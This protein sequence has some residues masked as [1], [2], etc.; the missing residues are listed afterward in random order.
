MNRHRQYGPLDDQDEPIGDAAFQ[1]LDMQ[2]DPAALAPG[3]VTLSENFRFNQLLPDGRRGAL[4][5][6]GLRRRLAPGTDPGTIL[7]VGIYRPEGSHDQFALVTT[8]KLVIF[9]PADQTLTDY[10]YLGGQTV[11]AAD[12]PDFIQG[13]LDTGTTPTAWILRGLSKA[14]LQFD[15]AVVAVDAAFRR[16]LFGMF[17]ENNRM[18]VASGDEVTPATTSQEVSVS[19]YLDFTE[20]SLLNQ[21]KILTGGDDHLMAFL[22]YQKN[23]ALIA[24]RKRF[25]IAHFEPQFGT[26]GAQ[27]GLSETGSFLRTLTRQGGLVARRAFLEAGGLVWALSD[28]GIF[29]FEPRLDLELTVLGAPL[30][31]PIQPIMDRL[32]AN[33]SVGACAAHLGD[34]LFWALP[35]SDAPLGIVDIVVVGGTATLEVSTA[36][37]AVAGDLIQNCNTATP[38]LNGQFTV[39]GAPD[40]THLTF[41]TSAADGSLVGTRATVQHLATRNNVVAVFNLSRPYQDPLTGRSYPGAWESIDWL[42]PGVYADYLIVADDGP[43]R[44]LWMIDKTYGPFSYEDGDVDETGAFLGGLRTGATLPAQLGGINRTSVA[45]AGRLTSRTLRWG[46][47]PRQVRAG[48]TRLSVAPGDAG[49]VTYRVRTPD[50][51]VWESTRTF[52]GDGAADTNAR[53]RCGFRGLEAEVDIITTAGRPAVR[54]VGFALAPD[55]RVAE[56]G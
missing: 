53:K 10:N 26:N 32:N 19:D 45:I 17:D 47:N 36:H 55:G 5:R 11:A 56:E 23:Y 15:G 13:G 28:G 29:A 42:P 27:Y 4:P 37:G 30:S 34:H 14:A 48:E 2:G 31:T 20:W 7:A 41:S 8:S 50:R 1:R 33:S 39:T 54:A 21:F 52:D 3:T 40:A 43:R 38:E 35:I 51:P 49:T 22:P 25:F 46:P 12:T 18:V 44:R 9:D 16:G 24:A 6:A